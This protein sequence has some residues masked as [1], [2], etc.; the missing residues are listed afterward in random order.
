MLLAQPDGS[1]GKTGSSSG[2]TSTDARPSKDE[3]FATSMDINLEDFNVKP[4]DFRMNIEASASSTASTAFTGQSDS[5]SKNE[6]RI[7]PYPYRPTIPIKREFFD[8]YAAYFYVG[9]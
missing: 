9:S 8:K 2:K 4:G 6:V 5:F 7:Q 3:V 1:F